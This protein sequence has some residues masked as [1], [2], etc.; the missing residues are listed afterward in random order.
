MFI[1]VIV[2]DVIT[3]FKDVLVAIRFTVNSRRR[4]PS[5][6]CQCIIFIIVQSK[7]NKFRARD[8]VECVAHISAPKNESEN[9]YL[10]EI[11]CFLPSDNLKHAVIDIIHSGGLINWLL[12]SALFDSYFLRCAACWPACCPRPNECQIPPETH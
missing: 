6:P 8:S 11:V 9:H 10:G 7:S 1:A 5:A 4:F 3:N 2:Q 12:S